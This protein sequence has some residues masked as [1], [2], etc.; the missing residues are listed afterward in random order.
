M[1]HPTKIIPILYNRLS[2]AVD[3]LPE[4][5]PGRDELAI[6]FISHQLPLVREEFSHN[7][8]Q[9]VIKPSGGDNLTRSVV[10]HFAS[11]PALFA[12]EGRMRDGTIEI[13][14]IKIFLD[15]AAE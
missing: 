15:P 11:T 12:V 5:L 7:W 4:G 9:L 13:R 3:G 10:G 2:F 1:K 8:D 14:N 6:E